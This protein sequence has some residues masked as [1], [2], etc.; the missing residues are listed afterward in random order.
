MEITISFVR[1]LHLTPISI[2]CTLAILHAKQS[3]CE[4]EG[5]K[6]KC[7]SATHWMAAEVEPGRP[8]KIKVMGDRPEEFLRLLKAA[9]PREL[10]HVQVTMQ[11]G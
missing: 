7:S 11:A 5:C 4:F 10:N 2:I 6:W 3:R 1:R 9:I 8:V